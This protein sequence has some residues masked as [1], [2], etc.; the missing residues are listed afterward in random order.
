MDITNP[1]YTGVHRDYMGEVIW[2]SGG[3]N[4][5]VRKLSPSHIL[6]IISHLEWLMFT[7]YTAEY[8]DDWDTLVERMTKHW[9]VLEFILLEAGTRDNPWPEDHP[10]CTTLLDAY[11]KLKRGVDMVE[12]DEATDED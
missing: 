8:T 3:K 5:P 10:E 2:P 1:Y 6:N 9:P 4:I 11:H 12:D 7:H